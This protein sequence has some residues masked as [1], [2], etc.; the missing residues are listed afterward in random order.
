MRIRHQ[1]LSRLTLLRFTCYRLRGDVLEIRP[2]GIALELGDEVGLGLR[3]HL[4]NGCAVLTPASLKI[5]REWSYPSRVRDREP[6]RNH[7]IVSFVEL[8]DRLFKV[9]CVLRVPRRIER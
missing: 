1:P 8:G 3:R 9:R 7:R 4:S 6:G 5:L 2:Y